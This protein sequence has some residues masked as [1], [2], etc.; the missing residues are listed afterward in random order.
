MMK[1][2]L[3]IHDMADL[4]GKAF[5]RTALPER[6]INSFRICG[7]APFDP[8][9]S[10][11]LTSLWLRWQKKAYQAMVLRK[12]KACVQVKEAWKLSQQQVMDNVFSGV[13]SLAWTLNW[14][15]QV[16]WPS[17]VSQSLFFTLSWA[18]CSMSSWPGPLQALGYPTLLQMHR[19]YLQGLLHFLTFSNLATPV[20]Q[21][22]IQTPL[23]VQNL[24]QY[25]QASNV[26]QTYW[27]HH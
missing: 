25:S 4:T 20:F 16:G 24:S 5:L 1:I 23:I 12:Q 7:L 13:S 15:W 10:L 2:S 17:H 6:A 21:I 8:V 22:V 9:S 11:I 19:N 26:F 14:K 3:L 27:T 18:M